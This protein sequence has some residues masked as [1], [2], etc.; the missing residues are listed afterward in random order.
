MSPS[1][2]RTGPHTYGV[3]Q[4]PPVPRKFVLTRVQKWG[5]PPLFLIPVLAMAG[6]FGIT[7]ERTEV[8]SG[9]LA[10][11]VSYPS[12]LRFKV[13]RPLVVRVQNQG[14][15]TL[16][17]VTVAFSNDYLSAFSNVAFTPTPDTVTAEAFLVGLGDLAPGAVREV[18]V[19][20]QAE[21]YWAHDGTVSV[22]IDGPGSGR[23]ASLH[24]RTIVLP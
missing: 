13:I 7:E 14:V 3:P 21:D 5:L 17:S 19:E 1:K 23:D 15:G 2:D 6:A 16:N 4:P 24:I 10:V 9:A 22:T 8:S 12:V 20:L 18:H 11:D